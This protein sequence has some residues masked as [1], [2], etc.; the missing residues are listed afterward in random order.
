MTHRNGLNKQQ[1]NKEKHAKIYDRQ[2]WFS[3]LLRYPARKRSGS[4]LKSGFTPS[5]TVFRK[6]VRICRKFLCSFFL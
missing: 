4:I 6:T 2:T 1:Y 3:R 5:S